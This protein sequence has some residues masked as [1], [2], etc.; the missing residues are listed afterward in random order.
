MGGQVTFST[1][2][3]TLHPCTIVDLANTDVTDEDVKEISRFA[4]SSSRRSEQHA[5]DRQGAGIPRKLADAQNFVP[6]QQNEIRSTSR[7]VGVRLERPGRVKISDDGL[8]VIGRI[9]SLEELT[10]RGS[11]VTT[12]A[13][14]ICMA[15]IISDILI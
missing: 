6:E 15:C 14:Q 2:Q 13:C 4:I 11:R 8:A 10:L 5:C 9:G 12:R 7:H 1:E 3:V